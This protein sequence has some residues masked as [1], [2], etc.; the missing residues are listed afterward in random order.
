MFDCDTAAKRCQN[1]WRKLG[2]LYEK[3]AYAAVERGSADTAM[4]CARMADVCFWQAT[5]EHDTI[6][7]KDVVP[8]PPAA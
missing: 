4:K 1:L 3:A 6:M 2:G 7:M 8:Q 5:G